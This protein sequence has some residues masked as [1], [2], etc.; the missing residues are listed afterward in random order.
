MKTNHL[1][2]VLAPAQIR[3]LQQAEG[4]L[5]TIAVEYEDGDRWGT[6]A[7]SAAQS[8]QE[9]VDAAHDAVAFDKAEK[10]PLG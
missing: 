6:E 9:L 3:L 7:G 10:N 5:D 4:L 2:P 1:G 8:I